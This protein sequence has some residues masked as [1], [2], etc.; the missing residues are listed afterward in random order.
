MSVDISDQLGKAETW[1]VYL[2]RLYK[3]QER[4]TREIFLLNKKLNGPHQQA[5][6][7]TLARRIHEL[8]QRQNFYQTQV[9]SPS[10]C[11]S[12]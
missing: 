2:E 11:A 12:V 7:D 5:S 10:T 6:C 3:L 9:T 4:C 8:Q 1:E